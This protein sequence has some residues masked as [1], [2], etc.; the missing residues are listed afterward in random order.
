M[1][2]MRRV[3][4]ILYFE[5][6]V[7]AMSLL[8]E[9][10]TDVATEEIFQSSLFHAQS[11]GYRE[12]FG[13]L[14]LSRELAEKLLLLYCELDASNLCM[15]LLSR[16]DEVFAER[17]CSLNRNKVYLCLIGFGASPACQL[18]D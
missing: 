11:L 9:E 18:N 2:I 3:Q 12:G 13:C 14:K 16:V 7:D 4:G 1:Q 15:H 10:M 5:F 8:S 6:A 17:D